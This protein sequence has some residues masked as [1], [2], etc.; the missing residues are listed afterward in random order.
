MWLA[1]VWLATA[2]LATVP[3][4]LLFR[5]FTS[6]FT[7]HPGLL[8]DG[9]GLGAGWQKSRCWLRESRGEKPCGALL[10]QLVVLETW[11]A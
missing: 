9:K 7:S 4:P 3:L 10:Q 6:M 2:W 8:Q 5:Y 1:A 11:V